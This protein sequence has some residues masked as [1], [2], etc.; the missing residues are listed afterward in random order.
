MCVVW[1]SMKSERA[2]LTVDN[3]NAVIESN[4]PALSESGSNL[5]VFT[6]QINQFADSLR[7]LVSTNSPEIDKAVQN[8]ESSSEDLKT[9]LAD[10]RAGKGLVGDLLHNEQLVTNVA[11]ITGNLSITTSNL[12]RLGLWGILW[13]HK[14][15]KTNTPP[16]VKSP[17]YP[18]D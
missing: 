4:R 16:K 1:C 11:Q 10:V 8:I 17:Q 15:P 5:V 18:Y 9:I 6:E 3:L 12:N 7:S 2:Q 14:P 13:K